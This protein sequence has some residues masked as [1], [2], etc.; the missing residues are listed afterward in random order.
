MEQRSNPVAWWE[1]AGYDLCMRTRRRVTVTVPSEALA[2]A[3]ADVAAGRTTSVS[4]WVAAA[5]EAKATAESLGD[6]VRAIAAEAG[7][8]LTEK[9]LS[10]ARKRLDPSSLTPAL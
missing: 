10:W 6:V 1:F 7:S 2:L 5:M 3:E 9:E 4:A 8:P